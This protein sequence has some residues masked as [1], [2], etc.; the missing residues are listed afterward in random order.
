MG[1]GAPVDVSRESN[2]KLGIPDILNCLCGRDPDVQYSHRVGVP[3]TRISQRHM[4][5]TAQYNTRDD[6]TQPT[7]ITYML[8]IASWAQACTLCGAVVHSRLGE[9]CFLLNSIC[10]E[11]NT[12]SFSGSSTLS[13][14][15]DIYIHACTG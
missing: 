8:Y 12:V 10:P 13:V 11:F 2:R 3:E 7:T 4:Y 9:K 14:R 15:T 1:R 5:S 6:S